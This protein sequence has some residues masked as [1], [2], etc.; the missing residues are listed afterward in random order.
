MAAFPYGGPP[1][2]AAG[3]HAAVF[4]FIVVSPRMRGNVAVT[5]PRARSSLRPVSRPWPGRTLL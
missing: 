4:P 2:T 5:A 3:Q 1:P